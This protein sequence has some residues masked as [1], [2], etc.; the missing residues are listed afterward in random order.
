MSK[1][2]TVPARLEKSRKR[3]KKGKRM[4]ITIEENGKRY[5]S[6]SNEVNS[7]LKCCFNTGQ[8]VC[9]EPFKGICY[10]FTNFYWKNIKD[11][12][13]AGEK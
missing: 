13:K 12:E 4:K 9:K 7:C 11:L 2:F 3:P 5:E 1:Q 6:V 10:L 8:P